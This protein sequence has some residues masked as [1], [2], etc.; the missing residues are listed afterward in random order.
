ADFIKFMTLGEGN[1]MW[2]D[3]NGDVPSLKRSLDA[4]AADESAKGF[5]RIGAFEAANTSVPRALTPG[6]SEYSTIIDATW[7]D[8]RNGADVTE[9]LNAAVA[10]INTAL[11]KYKQ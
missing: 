2:L 1:D 11:E 5:L 10:Q 4:I 6:Y 9:A 7:E 3:I 8:V